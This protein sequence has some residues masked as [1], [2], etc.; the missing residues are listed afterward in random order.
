MRGELDNH[1]STWW[2]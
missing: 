1:T 2:S